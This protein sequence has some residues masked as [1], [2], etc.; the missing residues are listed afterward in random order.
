MKSPFGGPVRGHVQVE[1][2]SAYL[3]QQASPSERA[4]ID[5]HLQQCSQCQAELASLRRTV[6]LLHALPRVAVPRAFTLS[7]AQVGIRRPATSPGWFG[8]LV[9]GLGAVA[10]ILV[11]A[12]VAYTVLRPGEAPWN[13]PQTVARALPTP[14]P[15]ARVVATEPLAASAPTEAQAPAQPQAQAPAPVAKAQPTP[16]AAPTS[17]PES[18]EPAA[19]A[20]APVGEPTA[21]EEPPAT[22]QDAAAANAATDGAGS[23][24]GCKRRNCCTRRRHRA[25]FT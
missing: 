20:A 9:R 2:L 10:A 18:P 1:L 23:R 7:E 14:A 12:F 25:S 8:G 6:F 21:G 16:V 11:V 15:Q 22:A 4:Y 19:L 17:A 3:D 24:R 13:P 5:A